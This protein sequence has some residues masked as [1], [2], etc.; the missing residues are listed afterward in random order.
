MG[1]RFVAGSLGPLNVTLSLTPKVDDPSYRPVSFDEVATVVHRADPRSAR[2]RRR[3]APDRDDLRHAE[4]EGCDRGSA[5]RRARVAAL[6]LGH[7]RRP[8]RPDALGPDGRGVLDRDR[9]RATADRGRQLLA[10][11]EG[12]APA[13]GGSRPDC[14]YVHEQPPE[15][16]P[17]ERVRRLRRASARHGRTPP[18]VRRG[19]FVNIVGGCCGTTPDHIREIAAAV[20]GTVPRHVPKRQARPRYSGLEPFELGPDTGFVMIGE[21]TNVT[22]SARFRRLIEANDYPGAV[23]VALEQVRGGANILDVNMDADLL[24]AEQA[25]THL[26]QRDRDR[27]GGR[28]APDHGR[29]LA[30]VGA[31]GGL[32]VHPGQ[33]DRQLDQ[34]QGGRGAVPRAGAARSAATARASS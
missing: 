29:Q 33:G 13:R 16:G 3:P 27:A 31:R 6:D 23:D 7:D 1:D 14:R 28:A 5:R 15:R 9:A 30:L 22:G 24:D 11:R 26:P 19:G 4:R 32:Q 34:P 10:R 17:P 12:D 2:R 25:M 18:R 21:R 8:L 20:S